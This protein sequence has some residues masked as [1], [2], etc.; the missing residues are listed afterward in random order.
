MHIATRA[1]ARRINTLLDLEP[2][3]VVLADIASTTS[4]WELCVLGS[5][6]LRVWVCGSLGIKAEDVELADM[7]TSITTLHSAEGRG[8]DFIPEKYRRTRR[9]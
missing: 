4:A 1:D 3:S 2:G 9:D 5:K 8:Q 7:A 6:S